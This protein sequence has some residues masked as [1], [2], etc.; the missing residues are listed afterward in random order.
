MLPGGT[1][2][3]MPSAHRLLVS[4]AAESRLEVARRW[5]AE[6][7]PGEEH[8]VLAAHF[9]A[10]SDLV[11][12]VALESGGAVGWQRTTLTRLAAERAAPALA[13][14]GWVPVGRL[15]VEA[16]VARV[17]FDLG[18]RGKLGRFA[19]ARRG[20]GLARA[21]AGVL[22][23]LRGAGI[24]PEELEGE[25]PELAGILRAYDAALASAGL[26]D[27]A[28]VESL[29][30]GAGP[31]AARPL[32]A[33]DLPAPSATQRALLRSVL[34][35]G[36]DACFLVPAGDA[37]ARRHF[38]ELL[39]CR[40]ESLDAPAAGS[41]VSLQQN[42]FQEGEPDTSPDG[43]VEIFSAPGESRECVEIARRIQR[44]ARAGTRFDSMAVLLRSPEIYSAFLAE[45]LR[46]AGVPA[47][48][49]RGV[50]RP[51]PS[52]R[53]LAALLSCAAE[54]LSARRFAEYLS[55]GEVPARAPD[56]APPPPAPAGERWVPPDEELLAA[57]TGADPVDSGE[58]DPEA[59]DDEGGTLPAPRRWERLLVDAAVIGGRER[60]RRRLDGLAG[61]LERELAGLEDPDDPVAERL[62]RSRRELDALRDFALPLIDALAALPE[63]APW[64]EWI[65]ALSALASRALRR[66]ERVQS[67]LAELAPMAAVGPV[68]L[69]EVQLV[70]APRL[71]SAA[72]PP[73]GARYGKVFVGTPE[74]ARGLAFERVFVPGLA[75]KLFPRKLG[76]EP[77][78]LDRLRQRI[79]PDL[80]TRADRLEEERLALRLC[81]GAA[82]EAVV[83]SYPRLDTD[84]ARPRVPSFYA[85]ELL[86]AAEGTLPG[87]DALAR[88][89]EQVG[90][91]QLGWPAP[92]DARD[93]IDAAEYDLARLR[94][95]ESGD[96]ETVTGAARYLLGANAHLARALRFRARRWLAGWTPADGLVKPAEPGRR[97]LAPH[98][99]AVRSFSATALQH[100]AS[101]PYRFYLYAVWKLAPREEP[102]AIEE[103]DPLQR[104]SL[105]HDVQFELLVALRD[106]ELLPVTPERLE[107][108]WNHLDAV[109]AKVAARYEEDL[110]PAIERVWRDGVESVR[111]DLREWLRLASTDDSGF[112]PWR[113][114]LAFGLP[115]RQAADRA[116]QDAPVP[117][118][119]G[120]ALR[121]SID[122]VER[123]PD[124]RVR[125][126][127]HK[128]GSE[129]F[130]SGEVIQG[131][132]ALQPVLYALA[133][134]QLFPDDAVES[135]RLY[136][137][138]SAGDFQERE[139]PLDAAAR[140]SA[141]ALARTVD[142]ALEEPFLPAAPDAGAC[143]WCDYRSVCG[144]YEELRTSR[145]WEP[146][147]A[148]LKALRQLR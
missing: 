10:A 69:R 145:K 17:L 75:E 67:V 126:T 49:D 25:A 6:R 114:E 26:A 115:G 135:G 5:L 118:D 96:P 14:R 24:G 64:G 12:R 109:L 76:E 83:A 98:Q 47:H 29:A 120:L 65:E 28:R 105:V 16:V 91:A 97:A 131:G 102:E 113:F 121:G 124:G 146:P 70:L 78:L 39:G 27:R 100:Y 111:A 132:R 54:G 94:T 81:A 87:F 107:D 34:E 103:L 61:E 85:L 7:P 74:A 55:L 68:G 18:E 63:R 37:R 122:L 139:V 51:D 119:G 21:L 41:L 133:A 32:L 79:D 128:T 13:E 95:L 129:R 110:S 89:A 48:F 71:Q 77:I 45:A 60:W 57:R 137:C 43:A 19:E 66:P 88:R 147:L 35:G 38:E 140:D 8:W 86:R 101:C 46:R 141:R 20:P 73:P 58:A 15:A 99:L 127:D 33:I 62:S 144:P 52:G 56:G 134:E 136:Y 130:K 93:A 143:R 108:A 40:A 44:A 117:V 9:D 92:A 142:A 125:V 59:P 106:V 116:S 23:E 148:P 3:A 22:E 112:V 123:H 1:L 82:R 30:A 80:A 36:E 53:A 2:A 84:G 42:L 90:Q 11:R 138:T 4:S 72:A 31:P 104:G 50:R